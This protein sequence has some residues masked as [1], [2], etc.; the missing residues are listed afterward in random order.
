M[1]GFVQWDSASSLLFEFLFAL[2]VFVILFWIVRRVERRSQ[3]P[4]TKGGNVMVDSATRPPDLGLEE[5]QIR[6]AVAPEE[7]KEGPK[8]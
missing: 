7:R 3:A 6:G 8:L 5:V 1:F 4:L 2:A